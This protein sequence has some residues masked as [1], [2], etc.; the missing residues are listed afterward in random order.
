MLSKS[1]TFRIIALSGFWIVMALILTAL[2]LLFYYRDHIAKHYDAHVFMHLEEMVAASHLSPQGELQLSYYPSDPRFDILYS[3]W[4]WE[5]RHH[6]KVLGRSHSLGGATLDLNGLH[7]K[8]GTRIHQIVGPQDEPLR[9]Q[10]LEI[11]AGP[12]GER[13]ML[14]AT[15]P[16]LGIKDDVID[17]AEHMLVSFVL[18]AAV[19][20]LAVVLQVRLA[21]RPLKAV[22]RGIARIRGGRA[23]RL[24]GDFP[25]EVQP[26]VDELNNLLEHSAVLLKRARNQLGDLAHSIKNPLTVINNEAGEMDE[27]RRELLLK[28][29]RDIASSVEHYLSR[30]RVFGTEN[31]LGARSQVKAVAEDL[32]FVMQRIYKDRNLE[33]DL[34]GLGNCAFRG[35]SQDLEEMLG[36]LLDNAS[37]W[38]NK[39][40]IVHCQTGAQRLRLAVEDD[41]PGIP[42]VKTELVL[43]RGGKLDDTVAGHGR[44]L[45]I[46]RDIVGLYGG[47][48]TLSRSGYGGLSAELELPGA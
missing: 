8:E 7:V 10:T 27:Q 44:G 45:G 12:A 13:L 30:A 32:V 17:I 47:S 26:L 33:F 19:L 42:E 38:A 3:G 23:D 9:I 16:M 35:E 21:L 15:A 29:T 18:L 31:V 34:S 20:I 48:L 41:G 6:G 5:I 4:Y 24:E 28:Q 22:S 25:E 39:R 14:V 46:V 37:K 11:P 2:L 1:L 40:V 43:S 36:N